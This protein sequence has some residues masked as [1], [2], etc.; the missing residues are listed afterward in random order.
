MIR[1]NGCWTTRKSSKIA[2]MSPYYD[3]LREI[4]GKRLS[5]MQ[6]LLGESNLPSPQLCPV[7]PAPEF[8]VE[9]LKEECVPAAPS[10]AAPSIAPISTLVSTYQRTIRPQKSSVG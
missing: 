4:F 9:F 5:V 2:K 8:E 10:N 3:H 7:S 1:V 6:P